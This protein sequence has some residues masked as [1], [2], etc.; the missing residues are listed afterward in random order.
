[1]T[2]CPYRRLLLFLFGTLSHLNLTSFACLWQNIAYS[3]DIFDIRLRCVC[4]ECYGLSTL[5]WYWFSVSLR[6][7][8][9]NLNTCHFDLQRVMDH[10]KIWSVNQLTTLVGWQ[11][12]LLLQ[13]TVLNRSAVTLLSQILV[14]YLC[15]NVVTSDYSFFVYIIIA[16]WLSQPLSFSVSTWNKKGWTDKVHNIENE[17][18]SV[19]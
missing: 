7:I 2:H 1:M 19:N 18:S 10:G 8:I 9:Y 17:I 5:V 13:L 16:I 11:Y 14:A 4:N 6:S 12:M 15:T 3:T